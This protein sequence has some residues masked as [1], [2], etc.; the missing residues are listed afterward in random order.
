MPLL[1]E[2]TQ[3]IPSLTKL[4][5]CQNKNR[6][7][8]MDGFPFGFDCIP[9]PRPFCSQ[10]GG[11]LSSRSQLPKLRWVPKMSCSAWTSL[12]ATMQGLRRR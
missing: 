2:K 1:E 6:T 9:T 5:K 12:G 11:R 7:P 8:Q 3:P 10:P 4:G